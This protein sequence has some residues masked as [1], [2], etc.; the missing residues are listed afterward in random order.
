M[1]AEYTR[2]WWA[3]NLQGKIDA[4]WRLREFT[5]TKLM[6][7]VKD[8]EDYL[9]AELMKSRV[10]ELHD[11]IM[12][13]VPDLESSCLRSFCSAHREHTRGWFDGKKQGMMWALTIDRPFTLA[14]LM[15]IVNEIKND[16][17]AEL[18]KRELLELH[19]EILNFVPEV[20]E[21]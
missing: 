7:V 20:C 2:G 10:L 1:R 5:L 11:Q 15:K 13:F 21:V 17:P 12:D 3:G 6:N 9:P 14:E 16:V 18:V 19:Q 8:I 4:F